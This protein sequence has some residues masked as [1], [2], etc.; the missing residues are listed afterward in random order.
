MFLQQEV[1]QLQ[2]HIKDLEHIVR[3]NKEA[4]K[5]ATQ[6]GQAKQ[7]LA[8]KS[9]NLNDETSTSYQNKS[10]QSLVE[11][12]QEENSRLLDII[13][14][15]KKE[16]NI[17]Q[18][19]ALISEQICE[20]AQRHELETVAE[21]EEKISDL[22]KLL[23]DKEYAIQE[24]EKIKAIPEQEGVVVKFREVLNPTEQNLKLHNEIDALNGMLA[25]VSKE[26]N[27]LQA[28]NQQL[29]NINF[30]RSKLGNNH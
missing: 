12:L 7:V 8:N 21:L 18:S 17:A 14:K 11:H 1:H 3:I 6:Q 30:V 27:K 2:D 25:K 16:R 9:D 24:L 23:Q 5:I 15:V 19:K 13:E 10:L 29:Q 28:E 26:L 22:R 20:E 4:L